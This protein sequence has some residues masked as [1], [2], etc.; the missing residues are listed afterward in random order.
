MAEPNLDWKTDEMLVG[1]PELYFLATRELLGVLSS[2]Y[3]FGER[4]A[5]GR[6]RVW[7]SAA[8][9]IRRAWS[10][11]PAAQ[12]KCTRPWYGEVATIDACLSG[13]RVCTKAVVPEIVGELAD[14]ASNVDSRVAYE[15][16]EAASREIHWSQ[17]FRDISRSQR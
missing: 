6:A 7:P 9:E 2:C 14:R 15:R 5:E 4:H 3:E 10:L 11:L 13:I 8:A 17:S 16:K 12:S 1:S